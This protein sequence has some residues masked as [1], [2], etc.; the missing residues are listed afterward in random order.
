MSLAVAG[1]PKVIPYNIK[2][3]HFGVIRF[4]DM[5]QTLV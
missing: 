5:L 1:Y 4:L 2:F 3:E